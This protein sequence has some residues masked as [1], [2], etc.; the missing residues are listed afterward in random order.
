MGRTVA[1]AC[2]FENTDKL[3]ARHPAWSRT[4]WAQDCH[5]VPVYGNE[6]FFACLN[7][8]Q[9]PPGVIPQLSRRD[10]A[11]VHIVAYLRRMRG[12]AGW[13]RTFRRRCGLTTRPGVTPFGPALP[14]APD[15]PAPGQGPPPEITPLGVRQRLTVTAADLRRE[16]EGQPVSP[17]FVG[18]RAE[19]AAVVDAAV[20]A[21]S[22]EPG[23]VLVGGEASVGK[24]RLVD[25]VAAW[26]RSDGFRVLCGQCVEL[27]ADGLPFAP[28]VGA[29]P[30]PWQK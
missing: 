6:H 19:P 8:A 26:E 16:R 15:R 4:N 14:A 27:G 29:P 17:V 11:H 3:M 24:S 30:T 22:G 2:R 12:L 18:R 20:R 25:E 13:S 1:S 21:R 28:L 9:E 10:L 5:P 7:P 23:V